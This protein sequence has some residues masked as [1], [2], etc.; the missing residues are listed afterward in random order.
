MPTSSTA[1][2]PGFDRVNAFIAGGVFLISFIVYAMTVQRTFSF[3]DCGEFIAAS[4]ILGIPHPPGTPLFVVLG[5][6]MAVI[7][8]V[9]DISHRIN[10]IS[11]I[12]SA[13]TAM[14][15][16]LLTVRLVGYFFGEKRHEGINRFIAYI[17]GVAGAF[18]VAFSDTIWG[19]A[20]EAERYGLALTISMA[21]VWLAVRY[22]ERRGTDSATILMLMAIYLA[23]LGI[24]I[25]MTV[26]LV[27]P[28]CAIFFVL[29]PSATTRDWALL[30]GFFVVELLLILLFADGRGGPGLF[31]LVTALLALALA[32]TLRRKI[33]WGI[34]IALAS[35]GSVM[36]SFT[37]YAEVLPITVA[38]LVVVGLVN[39]RFNLQVNWKASL[40]L[41]LVAFIGVSVHFIIP[42]RS[43]LNP[44]I[45]ENNP[46]RDFRTFMAFLDRKQ[47]GQVSMVDRMFNRR[48][49]LE[50]QFGRHANM[51]FWSYFEQQYSPARWGFAPFFILGLVGVAFAIKRKLKIGFPFFVLLLLT[52]AGL[53]L[54]MNF[55]DGTQYNPQTGDAYMEVRNRNYFFTPGFAFFGIA[56]GVGVAAVMTL[57]R[58][59][60]QASNPS[61][62]R[63]SVYL[64]SLL[65]FLPMIT[66]ANNWHR[67]DR[68]DNYTPYN[69]AANILD[70]CPPNSILFTSG[71]ND[72]FPLWAL[73]E[74]YD[75][76]KDV[77]VVNLSLLNTDWYVE[78][79]KNR[80]GVPISLTKDQILWHPFEIRPGIQAPRPR[81]QFHDRPRKRMTFLQPSLWNNQQ[82]KVQDMM[83]DEI[84]IENAKLGWKHPIFFTSQPYAES[85]LK[86]QEKTVAYGMLYK[87][88]PQPD[89]P[90][91]VVD[92]G[93]HLY[94]HVY[95]FD[96]LEDADVF[97]DENT[98]GVFLGMGLGFIR[99]FDELVRNGQVDSAMALGEH[100]LRVF[101]EYWQTYVV[102]AEQYDIRGDTASSSELF[103]RLHDTLT[104]F[105]R[106][107]P[108]NY[109][110]LGDL[111][112]AKVE[113][114]DRRDMPEMIED[115]IAH[116]WKAFQIN[117]NSS[118]SFRK[119]IS[120]LAQQG[121]IDEMRRAAAIHA[122]YKINRQD[123]F[124]QRLLGFGG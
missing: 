119:L 31:Y 25:H 86:L 87:L 66:L 100:M 70:T 14:L 9:E 3:W 75:Y 15:S 54:Y 64:T 4:A 40:L 83:V 52:T 81:E 10:Y 98:T 13:V 114:G 27:L 20:V 122:E 39:K 35:I 90:K 1:S 109:F 105:V 16:Y 28:A 12:G 72:T 61:L 76:R 85:P 17:G 94:R 121:R 67:N 82:V 79:M 19:N 51:G 45:D 113:L 58:D 60:L 49:L 5:R 97:R 55:A 112:L 110:Y 74:A 103:V 124:V 89:S 80:Y 59:R 21:I 123:T 32:F 104:S 6:I 2:N 18:F 7:P 88:L 33:R 46:S 107:N 62:A 118:Y 30:C 24:A 73:Q 23:T 53:I 29:K 102:M 42:I 77:V 63:N 48:G 50:N 115:G 65:V 99:I 96:G 47:Y 120:V 111:G 78:Q 44:R 95:R 101:P 91:V 57:V 36:M 71:D 11:V 37:A 69:Y 92:T 117:P 26:F 108:G 22:Y 41:V 38:V 106:S 34:L 68:S 43:E 93:Y 8:F 84:V 56:M 116:L